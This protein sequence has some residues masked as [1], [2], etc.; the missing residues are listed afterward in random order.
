MVRDIINDIIA[1][2]HCVCTRLATGVLA[3]AADGNCGECG[4]S[5]QAQASRVVHE[6]SSKQ[7]VRQPRYAIPEDI[8]ACHSRDP[9]DIYVH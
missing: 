1:Y 4:T 9:P 8:K 7:P 6:L 2:A 3:S 5:F